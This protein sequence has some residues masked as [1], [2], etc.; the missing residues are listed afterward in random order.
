MTRLHVLA[1]VVAALLQVPLSK[2]RRDVAHYSLPSSEGSLAAFS[3]DLK[4]FANVTLR[5]MQYA[6]TLSVGTPPQDFSLIFDT[7]SSVKST[8]WLWVPELNCS[9]HS[10]D[11]YF[12][13][14]AS[15]TYST[16]N[17]LVPLAYGIGLASGTLSADTM[18]IGG[19][20]AAN[21]TFV[22]VQKDSDFDGLSADG[23]FG[24]GFEKLADNYTTLV[25]NLKR[26][27]HISQAVFS[28]YLSDNQFGTQEETLKSNIII[29]GYDLET[30]SK[31]ATE[32]QVNYLKVYK[33]TGYWAVALDSINFGDHKLF[34]GSQIAILDTGTSLILGPSALVESLLVFMENRYS[35][36]QDADLGMLTCP[37]NNAYP[38]LYFE[39]EGIIFEVPPASYLYPIAESCT[40]LITSFKANVWILGDVFLRNYYTIYD[41][42]KSRIG[43][44]GSTYSSSYNSTFHWVILIVVGSLVLALFILGLIVLIRKCLRRWQDE[45]RESYIALTNQSP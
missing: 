23:V 1:V 42:D 20:S 33:E 38:S 13:P 6:G 41:M 19:V 2:V 15:L 34:N 30:Y 37:C 43:L 17:E 3:V 35:C 40:L 28:I 45:P 25:E 26:Q 32:S 9:C 16:T 7:G 27:G 22:L 44:V 8:Q 24:L 5:Q 12:D 4:N 31:N 14:K 18:G 36:K 10:A 21:Q 11:S 39:L 29:G